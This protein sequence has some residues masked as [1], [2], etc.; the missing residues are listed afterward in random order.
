MSCGGKYP[1]KFEDDYDYEIWKKDVLIW[2]ELTN[3]F[4][5]D[6]QALAIHLALSGR[7]RIA[8]SQL[9]IEELKKTNGVEILLEKLKQ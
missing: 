4:T 8:S 7:A 2:C 6:K 3:D 5:K 1:T 9:S